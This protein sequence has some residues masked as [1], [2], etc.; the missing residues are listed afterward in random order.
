MS[1]TMNP[2]LAITE[3]TTYDRSQHQAPPSEVARLQ[4][5]G[6][7]PGSEWEISKRKRADGNVVRYRNN[8][9]A[10]W[11]VWME[12]E[13]GDQDYRFPPEDVT[14]HR[15]LIESLDENEVPEDEPVV[16]FTDDMKPE[17]TIDDMPEPSRT[18]AKN[19][20][21]AN[22]DREDYNYEVLNS[23]T[24][25]QLRADAAR[26]K[27]KGRGSMAKAELIEA[28]MAEGRKGRA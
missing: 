9:T 2:E 20:E 4:G 27:I 17:L 19:I 10:K 26:L 21:Q 16:R 23:M 28:L 24:R 15:V 11:D 18:A 5:V 22:T 6:F 7:D 1:I 3:A 25:D 14:E 13:P 12:L 8:V